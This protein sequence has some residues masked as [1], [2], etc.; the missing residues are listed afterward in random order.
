MNAE[1]ALDAIRKIVA[2]EQ[3]NHDTPDMDDVEIY[4]YRDIR[5]IIE[6][7]DRPGYANAH[8]FPSY[9]NSEYGWTGG[10]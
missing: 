8:P 7:L 1:Q 9:L 5:D 6:N 2:Y 10:N 4:A 3:E